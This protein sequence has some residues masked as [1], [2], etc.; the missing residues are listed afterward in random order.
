[1]VKADFAERRRSASRL[2]KLDVF[3][4]RFKVPR[5][6]YIK[7]YESATRVFYRLQSGRHA[8][9]TTEIDHESRFF[10]TDEVDDS[11]L[12][13]LRDRS[14]PGTSRVTT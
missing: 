8:G 4:L 7:A 11:T 12:F 14:E 3:K 2:L 5:S 1:M 6:W 9:G 10:V 13:L